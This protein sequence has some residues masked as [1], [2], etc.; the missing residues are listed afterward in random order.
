M[1]IILCTTGL[2]VCVAD[3]GIDLNPGYPSHVQTQKRPAAAS[4]PGRPGAGGRRRVT[5]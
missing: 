1:I 2:T 3:W 4:G 5:V